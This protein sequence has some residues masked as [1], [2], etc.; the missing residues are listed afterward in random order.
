MPEP[1]DYFANARNLAVD[2]LRREKIKTPELIQQTAEK[3][4]QAQRIFDP[5]AAVDVERLTAELR[6]LFS[7]GAEAATA[8]DDPTEH[9][10]YAHIPA[11]RRHP[12]S[13][14]AGSCSGRRCF[15]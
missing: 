9:D 4:A 1:H 6:H 3:A 5:T 12:E 2:I 13:R 11:M 15:A 7:V 8:L 14:S 10:P